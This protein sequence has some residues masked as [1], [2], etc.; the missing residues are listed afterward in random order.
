MFFFM[1][2]ASSKYPT[3]V[4]KYIIKLFSFFYQIVTG[5]AALKGMV[6]VKIWAL[7]KENRCKC[8]IKL[9]RN[10]IQRLGLC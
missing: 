8:Q 9:G 7:K 3:L 4:W 10:D 6:R 1:L 2:Q 5:A